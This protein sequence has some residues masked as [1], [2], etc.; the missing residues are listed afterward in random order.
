[1]SIE[2][3][4]AIANKL[5]AYCQQNDDEKCLNELYAAEAVSI[6]ATTMP[7]NDS[8]QTTGLDGI[9]AKHEW[10]NNNFE[11]HSS[12]AQGPFFHGEDRFGV[13]F[14][15]D[16]TNKQTDERES[17]QELGLYTVQEG[18]IIKE[19]FYYDMP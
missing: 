3:T 17:M 18:K 8:P 14:S 10:W 1:M 12:S 2:Q 4:K 6:E 15:F 19:E 16:A 13:I 9:R 11:V 5:V 7:G